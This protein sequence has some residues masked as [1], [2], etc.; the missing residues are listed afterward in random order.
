LLYRFEV[1]ELSCGEDDEFLSETGEAID[2]DLIRVA[3]VCG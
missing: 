1:D 3:V 2:D